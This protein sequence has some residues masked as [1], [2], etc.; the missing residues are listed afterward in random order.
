MNTSSDF[1]GC[2]PQPLLVSNM[3]PIYYSKSRNAICCVIRAKDKTHD[4]PDMLRTDY[5]LSRWDVSQSEL[6][7][8]IS[9]ETLEE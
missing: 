1:E 8:S 3:G 9:P 2:F 5:R 4:R 6:Y 7:V